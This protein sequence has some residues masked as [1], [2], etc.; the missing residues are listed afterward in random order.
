LTSRSPKS[1][2]PF[3]RGAFPRNEQSKKEENIVEVEFAALFGHGADDQLMMNFTLL[4]V[5]LKVVN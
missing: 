2:K 3:S 1:A 5:L 4:G